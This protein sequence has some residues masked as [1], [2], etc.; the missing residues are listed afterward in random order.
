MADQLDGQTGV[1]SELVRL[2]L[3][4]NFNFNKVNNCLIEI[5]GVALGKRRCSKL[6]DAFCGQGD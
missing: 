5:L 1:T 4:V 3:L 6:K 2:V